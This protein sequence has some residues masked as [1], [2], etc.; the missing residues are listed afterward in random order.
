M[1]T[2][3]YSAHSQNKNDPP[4]LRSGCHHHTVTIVTDLL[5]SCSGVV[6][7]LSQITDFCHNKDTFVMINGET[8][9]AFLR[10]LS[11]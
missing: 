3:V 2:S 4:L 6:T 9:G 1:H 7:D 8:R 5:K 10:K 11:L